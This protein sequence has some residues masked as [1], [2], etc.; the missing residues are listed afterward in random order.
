MANGTAGDLCTLSDVQGYLA[1]TN[2]ASIPQLQALIT[3]VSAWVEGYCERDFTGI[4]SYT[5]L[6]DGLGGD[7][8]PLP[9]GPVTGVTSVTLD[10]S[11]VL[12]SSG[13]PAY[14]YLADGRS[15]TII[16]GVFTR[17]KKNV[18]IVYAAGYPYVFTPGAGNDPAKD[19]LTGVPADLRFAV[20]ETVALR[21]KGITRIGKNSENIQGQTTSY[22]N[23]I[24]PKDALAIFGIYKR[25]TPW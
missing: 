14:G 6:T 22:D 4:V 8:L 25:N 10:G 15:I 19:V 11:P 5:W 21:F 12:P 2:A 9:N 13:Y 17:A 20:V 16:G 3:Q 23:S 1:N 24:A 7:T 18:Q